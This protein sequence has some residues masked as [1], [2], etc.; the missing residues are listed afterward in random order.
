MNNP[1]PD[2][3]GAPRRSISVFITNLRI[4]LK[5]VIFDFL[6]HFVWEKRWFFISLTIG[7]LMLTLLQPSGLSRE[8]LIVLS[9]SVVATILFITEPIPLPAVALLII[10]GQVF[11]LGTSSSEVAKTLWNDSVLFIMGSLCSLLRL[12]SKI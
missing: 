10:L 3:S 6:T 5:Q 4:S 11:L 2:L 1:S 12:L 7:V 9:M 8:G